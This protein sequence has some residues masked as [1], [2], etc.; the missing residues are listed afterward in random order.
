MTPGK[1]VQEYVTKSNF[2]ALCN[3]KLQ[4][5]VCH[6]FLHDR[7]LRRHTDKRAPDSN[8]AVRQGIEVKHI[9]TTV[10]KKLKGKERLAEALLKQTIVEGDAA[11][12]A[13]IADKAALSEYPAGAEIIREG[14]YGNELFMILSGAVSVVAQGREITRR[15]ASHHVG[16]M[17]LINP[18]ASRSASV[19]ALEDTVCAKISEPDFTRIAEKKPTLWRLLAGELGERIGKRNEYEAKLEFAV[20]HDA[21]TWLPNRKLF[22][23]RFGEAIR[24]ARTDNAECALLYLDLD[25]FKPVNDTFGHLTGDQLL[26]QVADRIRLCV[27]KT[28]TVARVG[29][30]EFAVLLTGADT[31]E[32][33]STIA[34][35]LVEELRRPF[36]IDPI[37][38]SVSASVGIAFYPY[39]G[40]D[41]STLMQRADSA[42]YDAKRGGRDNYRLPV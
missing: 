5:T 36:R 10:T 42:L 22:S 15:E 1:F 3:I 23:E 20:N 39:H 19:F 37:Y 35:K 34:A 28:T 4:K 31:R 27:D 29:G 12:A 6:G 30:D 17:A 16:E 25:K 7:Y 40:E 32:A 41:V 13:Q 33:A 14:E 24:Q 38:V 11:L 2:F 21:L 18:S 9:M 26:K 8:G